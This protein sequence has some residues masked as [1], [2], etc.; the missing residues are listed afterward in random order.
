MVY[1]D[2]S[3]YLHNNTI[4]VSNGVITYMFLY[5]HLKTINPNATG[6]IL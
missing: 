5:G 4:D 3:C 6:N 2:N 1:Y